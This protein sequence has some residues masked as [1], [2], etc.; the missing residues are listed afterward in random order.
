MS[1]S[2]LTY[3]HSSN[4]CCRCCGRGACLGAGNS[5]K[6]KFW[7]YLLVLRASSA[8]LLMV[9]FVVPFHVSFIKVFCV[10]VFELYLIVFVDGIIVC[11]FSFIVFDIV[12][13]FPYNGTDSVYAVRSGASGVLLKSYCPCIC[14]QLWL[15]S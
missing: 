6:S 8:I 1:T 12:E 14:A 4:T 10:A 2:N 13:S 5:M 3:S 11:D 15:Y 9:L 7:S